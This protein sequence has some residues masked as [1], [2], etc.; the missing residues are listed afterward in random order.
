MKCRVI[1]GNMCFVRFDD[2]DVVMRID[3]APGALDSAKVFDSF[4]AAHDVAMAI[5]ARPVFVEED[6]G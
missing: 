4:E 5:G 3:D 2:M 6:E 1:A